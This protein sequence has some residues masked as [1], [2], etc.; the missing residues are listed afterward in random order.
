MA[1]EILTREL[2]RH[3]L[4]KIGLVPPPNLGKVGISTDAFKLPKTLDIE[5]FND[6]NEKQVSSF[7]LWCGMCQMGKSKMIALATDLFS[8]DEEYHEFCAV[9][10]VDDLAIHGVKHIFSDHEEA[11][12]IIARDRERWSQ[13]G[14]YDKL[15]VTAGME[16]LADLGAT[17]NP[18][19]EY[20][21]LYARLIDLVEM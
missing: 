12:F 2:V 1:D 7:P 11:Q 19:A 17:W 16:R 3:V 18:C 4:G 20:E 10:C 14:L 13:L 15:L 21:I 9:F 6:T 5:Y 8:E